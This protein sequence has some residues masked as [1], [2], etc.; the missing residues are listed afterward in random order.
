MAIFIIGDVHGHYYPLMKLLE[1]IHYSDGDE[2]W[3]VGDLVNRGKDSAKVLEFVKNLKLKQVVL[4]NHDFSILTQSYSSE[5]NGT[6]KEI[7]HQKNGEELIDSLRYYP[8]I[9][10]HHDLKMVMTHAGI[11]PKWSLEE[12]LSYGEEISLQLQGDDF[13]EFLKNIFGDEPSHWSAD[14]RGIN[15][16]RF[17]VNAFCRMRYLN[18]DVSLD[19]AEKN[20]PEKS[21]L[22]PWFEFN[23]TVDYQQYFGHW[24][25]LGDYVYKNIRCL[26][27]G[28]AWGGKLMAWAA[29]NNQLAGEIYFENQ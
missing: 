10:A 16:W 3:F 7:L 11:Y 22:K 12:A 14:L 21:A 6:A 19:F 13:K 27:G 9:V 2:L 26:D 15:R 25:S 4:G 18:A 29:K 17:I 28:Y 5:P 24:A 8:L 23:Q 20:S 1:K